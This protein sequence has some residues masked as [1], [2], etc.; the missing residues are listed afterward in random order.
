MLSQS[1]QDEPMGCHSPK[2][3]MQQR[4]GVQPLAEL[5]QAGPPLL[6][7]APSTHLHT[8]PVLQQ[9]PGVPAGV[10]VIRG[11]GA[12]HT[13]WVALTWHRGNTRS[14]VGSQEG[15][16]QSNSETQVKFTAFF[17]GWCKVC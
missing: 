16:K 14:S 2:H 8:V 11:L 1:L 6:V 12:A 3:S 10:T 17:P 13:V 7:E 4:R 15:A 9:L 5:T